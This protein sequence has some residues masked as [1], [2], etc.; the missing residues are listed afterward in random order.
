MGFLPFVKLGL[1]ANGIIFGSVIALGAIGLTLVYGILKLGNF[2]HG[3]YMAFGAYVAFFIV[4]GLLPRAGI[5]G[6]GLGPFTFGFPILIALPLS[7]IVVAL[8][9]IALDLLIYRR[10]R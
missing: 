7:A 5:D 10:L 4:D 2:A 8:G 3:D 9:A 6:A 1:V